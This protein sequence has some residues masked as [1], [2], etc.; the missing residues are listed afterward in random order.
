LIT[1][2]KTIGI[3]KLRDFSVVIKRPCAFGRG[4]F[5]H[6]ANRII[7]KSQVLLPH[8]TERRDLT[9]LVEAKIA[10]PVDA[11]PKR[12]NRKLLP[13]PIIIHDEVFGGLRIA[14][15]WLALQPSGKST[16]RVMVQFVAAT[17]GILDAP[18]CPI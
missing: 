15:G 18:Q 7:G 14:I 1:A 11:F 8:K 13:D 3:S 6:A 2:A 12:R 4:G 10:L 17:Q 5:G 16:R 9:V